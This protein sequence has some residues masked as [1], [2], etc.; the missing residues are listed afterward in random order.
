MVMSLGLWG[1]VFIICVQ[2]VFRS[3]QWQAKLIY[4]QQQVAFNNIL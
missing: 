2:V 3:K 1:Q 4:M